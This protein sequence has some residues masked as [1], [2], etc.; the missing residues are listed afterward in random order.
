MNLDLY[1][2]GPSGWSTALTYLDPTQKPLGLEFD[3]QA[4]ATRAAIGHLT[5]RCDIGSYPLAP[6]FGKVTG[7]TASPPCQSFSAS[8]KGEGRKHLD[9]LVAQVL[10]ADWSTDGLDDRTAHVL[11]TGRWVSTLMPEWVCFEQVRSVQPVWDAYAELLAGWGYSAWT[12]KLCAADYGTP[13]TRIRSILIASRAREVAV[14]APTHAKDGAGGLIPWVSMLDALGLADDG[15]WVL[16]RRQNKAPLVFLSGGRPAPTLTSAA[17]GGG[18]WTLH[19]HQTRMP[20]SVGVGLALQDFA[21]STP[22][23]GNKSRQGVQVGNAVPVRL[24]LAALQVATGLEPHAPDPTDVRSGPVRG[25]PCACGCGELTSTRQAE[26]KRGHRPPDDP[27]ERF[28]SQVEKSDGCWVWTGNVGDHHYGRF[29]N[30]A[31]QSNELAHRFS[32]GL[33]ESLVEGMEVDHLCRNRVC[34]RPDHL[35]QVTPAEN[36]R[37]EMAARPLATECHRGHPYDAEN[38]I[39]NSKGYRECRTCRRAQY[40]ARRSDD[41]GDVAGAATRSGAPAGVATPARPA[42]DRPRE[43]VGDGDERGRM[44]R[45]EPLERAAAADHLRGVEVGDGEADTGTDRGAGVAGEGGPGGVPVEAVGPG[46]GEGGPPGATTDEVDRTHDGPS[47]AIDSVKGVPASEPVVA[48]EASTGASTPKDP[49]PVMH[50]IT[51]LSVVKGGVAAT[52]GCSAVLPVM[53]RADLFE[54]ASAWY[55]LTTCLECRARVE[56]DGAH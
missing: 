20:M 2:G 30:P 9:R 7:I 11:H 47:R 33:T 48:A 27:A 52:V 24:A 44:A 45:F 4:C 28:F 1:G 35:E 15:G 12:G 26:Y 13:Q 55:S 5:L 25:R 54:N 23:V 3:A 53:P 39:T 14:P 16:D 22:L 36:R 6:F 18:V 21:A 17:I 8:G 51:S 32:K 41:G 46:D 38:T 40:E 50:L 37:R 49:R 42:D 10:D 34:V 29:W 19:H 31:T 43:E 56:H